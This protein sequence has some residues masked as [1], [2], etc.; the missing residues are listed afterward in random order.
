MKT[1]VMW[2]KYNITFWWGSL[3]HNRGGLH[4]K[5]WDTLTA[6]KAYGGLGFRK[7]HEYNQA[8]L[9]IKARYYPRSNFFEAKIGS[10]P[11]YVWRSI[12]STQD[13]IRKGARIRIGTGIDTLIW[14]QPW[15]PD[16]DFPYIVFTCPATLQ[17]S[18]VNSLR[19][20]EDGR[21]D[22]DI[23]Y[24]LFEERDCLESHFSW[25]IHGVTGSIS[26]WWNQ[27]V[28]HSGGAEL[29]VVAVVLWSIWLNRNE[30]VWNAKHKSAALILQFALDLLSQW[31]FAHQRHSS[32]S[33]PQESLANVHWLK[34]PYPS[35]KCNVDAALFENPPR[36]GFGCILR[37]H[38]GLVVAAIH[39]VILGS[40]SP[41]TA[42][43]LGIREA[44]SWIKDTNVSNVIV[45]SNAL[46]V[47]NALINP[48]GDASSHG[49]IL[50]DCL[51]LALD[52]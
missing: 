37:D 42:E 10:N 18:T 21:W 45:E 5:S 22:L 46:V 8:L 14:G 39:G 35:L 41:S 7:I 25:K 12:L 36:M 32:L 33:L 20:L 26:D 34:P 23:L 44:L 15:L 19:S 48:S 47:I 27:W 29:E 31:G 2:H 52:L 3:S 4:W 49:L 1:Y 13:L 40:F 43:A 28:M 6:H 38:L 51:V 16:P 11:S 30:V 24:D 9:V 50:E 17:R